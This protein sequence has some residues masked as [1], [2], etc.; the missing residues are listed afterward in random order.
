MKAPILPFGLAAGFLATGLGFP[1]EPAASAPSP[2]GF[3]RDA[4]ATQSTLTPIVSPVTRKDQ[5]GP[6]PEAPPQ[7]QPQAQPKVKQQ[8]RGQAPD[9]QGFGGGREGRNSDGNPPSFQRREPPGSPVLDRLPTGRDGNRGRDAREFDSPPVKAPATDRQ[10]PRQGGPFDGL[11]DQQRRNPFDA[12][13]PDRPRRNPFDQIDQPRDARPIERPPVTAPAV[14]PQGRGDRGRD[15][16]NRDRDRDRPRDARPIEQ[17]P[18]NAPVVDQGRRDWDRGRDGRG[19]GRDVGRDGRDRPNT[20]RPAFPGLDVD[21][22]AVRRERIEEAQRQRDQWRNNRDNRFGRI[23]DLRGRR[24]ERQIDGRVVIEEP[25]NR[26]IFRDGDRAFIRHDET[27]RFR[28]SF[29]DVRTENRGDTR[30]T[31][32]LGPGGVQI[33]TEQD[34]DGRLLRRYRRYR[35]GREAILIDNRWDRRRDRREGRRGGL[36]DFT[37]NLAP[38]VVRIP[39]ERYIVDYES[40]SDDLIY[41]TLAAPPVDDLRERY[42]LDEVRYNAPLRDRMR[43]VDLDGITFAFGSWEIEESQYGRLQRI[44]DAMLRVIDRN[45][46]EI[47]LI[48]GHTDAVGRDDDNLSLSDRRAETVAA[49]LTQEFGVPAENLTTQGYGEQYLKVPT[50][51]P[52]RLNRRCAV[53][54]ITPLISQNR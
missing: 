49:V 8:P 11:Q 21:F 14:D 42:T 26:R 16:R 10:L 17:P 35:D 36:F 25:G 18:V 3:H 13:P 5:G 52:E 30:T 2:G 54:R 4:M 29:R 1:V 44:A 45:E 50:D 53:R 22:D 48:E 38:P 12:I 39:R 24:N 20:G 32:A 51:G 7:E 9:Q 19:E 47:F 31:I 34:N 27:D 46:N 40:A 37:I 15:G 6:P 33:I 23:D 41:D 28:R 43:R